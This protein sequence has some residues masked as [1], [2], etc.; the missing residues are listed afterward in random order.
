VRADRGGSD[1]QGGSELLLVFVPER[2]FLPDRDRPVGAV[3]L[4]DTRDTSAHLGLVWL[5][6]EL[7]EGFGE[8]KPQ[9]LVQTLVRLR[10]A[11]KGPD[12][13]VG[14]VRRRN[15]ENTSAS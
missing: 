3:F 1:R 5:G 11:D 10:L 2:E 14:L 15:C 13:A 7:M 6:D 9:R 12:H 8:G 4:E